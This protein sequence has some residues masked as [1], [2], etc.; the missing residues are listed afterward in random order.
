MK[1][2]DGLAVAASLPG[3][4]IYWGYLSLRAEKLQLPF[5]SPEAVTHPATVACLWF[6]CCSARRPICASISNPLGDLVSSSA[7]GP[8]ACALGLL[9]TC[10]GGDQTMVNAAF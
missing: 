5:N 10:A 6:F 9:G 2:G 7:A 4:A 1:V 8:G 3:E